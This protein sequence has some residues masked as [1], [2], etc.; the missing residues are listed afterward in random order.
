MYDS[1]IAQKERAAFFRSL[2]VILNVVVMSDSSDSDFEGF[3][4]CSFDV[5]IVEKQHNTVNSD[6][7]ISLDEDISNGADHDINDMFHV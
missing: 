3:L 2:N 1:I 5:N 4:E 6:S 7:D